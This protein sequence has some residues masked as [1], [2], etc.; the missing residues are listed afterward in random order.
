MKNIL[1]IIFLCLA[2]SFVEAQT[3]PG[4]SGTKPAIDY[5]YFPS[6]MHA[7]V[8]RNWT[9]VPKE[10]LAGILGTSPKNVEKVAFSM[11]L[12]KQGKIQPEWSTSRGYITVLRRNWHLL[13]YD[14]LLELLGVSREE[15][16]FRLIEDDFLFVKLGNVKPFCEPLRYQEPTPEMNRRAAI[17]ASDIKDLGKGA[18]AKE[19]PRF[20]F[21]K[22]FQKAK[23]IQ[24]TG[25]SSN[26]DGFDLRMIYSYFA[27]FG[28]PLLD[29]ELTSYP[30]G[31]LQRLSS[32]GVNGI[33]L[34]SVLRM[35]V[36]EL[37]AFPGDA[38]APQRI[39][40]LK[41]LV[42]RAA[43]YGIKIYL[44]VNEPRAMHHDFFESNPLRAGWGGVREGDLQAFCT[45]N[46]DV[47]RWLSSSLE[48]VFRQVQGLGG[49]FTIT[50]SENLTSCAS[51][52]GY[53]Q[54]DK[55]RNHSF[56][57]LIVG[58]NMAISEG[59]TRGNP[60]AKVLVWDWGWMDN[61]AENIIHNLPKNCWLMSVSEWSM[62]IERGG[63]ASTVGEY[64][65][66]SV[67]PGPRALR[68]WAYAR[69]AG[70][71]T[72]A[73]VQVN[74]TWEIA[75]VP[76]IPALE[77]VASHAGNLS[78]QHIDGVMLS[79]SLGGYPS[80]NL[81]L[82]QSFRKGQKEEMLDQLALSMYGANAAPNVR[83]AWKL[84]SDAF[85]E[86]PYHIQTVYNG[87][88]QV[89]PANPFYLRPTGYPSTMV[90]IP[91][92]A[93]DTWRAVY[94]VSI[95]ISQLE[96]CS[97]G[98]FKG[99]AL[100]KETQK[101]AKGEFAEK[102]ETKRLRMEVVGIHL[103][104]VAEQSRFTNARNRYLSAGSTESEKKTSIVEMRQAAQKELEL[105]K[106]LLPLVKKDATIGYESS[107]HYFYLPVDLLEAH[108]SIQAV[109]KWIDEL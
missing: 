10:K 21:V 84:C 23:P 53:G 72:V 2:A 87:P 45:S 38:K 91:Y 32:E 12:P 54:C 7:F 64:S 74:V 79:W 27:D 5:D 73:K 94:P 57:D 39:D 40:G 41:R 18:F 65:I 106:S 99:A 50:A 52:G 3:L 55:C 16:A 92:D 104:S 14:Q 9:V 36:P 15:L 11:G 102:L 19:T 25:T 86:Y 95:Y 66:S 48:Q 71:K 22:E 63:V 85:R 69:E 89:G 34:H 49:V 56:A 59:V 44:Y 43:K 35:L 109:L 70:L 37:G 46:P 88:Q 47:L 33:W 76:A 105:I 30:E 29:T 42:E 82:F 13:P 28:D 81:N 93:V 83:K 107:N 67:G 75:A 26:Q 17:I 1:Y 24:A 98:F 20:S 77:L 6:R 97:D 58:V 101:K 61:E 62:P 108:I 60:E 78:E 96:K 4:E 51:H 100:L 31:L 8:W 90:G 80:E 68:H 103:R